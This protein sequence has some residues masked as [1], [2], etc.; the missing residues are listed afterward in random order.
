[1]SLSMSHKRPGDGEIDFSDTDAVYDHILALLDNLLDSKH[2]LSRDSHA[3]MAL[4]DARFNLQFWC[5]GI[6]I[7]TNALIEFSGHCPKQHA[8]LFSSFRRL[9]QCLS[10]LDQGVK[11][12]GTVNGIMLAELPGRVESVLNWGKTLSKYWKEQCAAA[13]THTHASRVRENEDK[14]EEYDGQRRRSKAG[15]SQQ[16]RPQKAVRAVL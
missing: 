10:T 4:L 3:S 6:F 5:S 9:L 15:G 13:G 7:E 14:G 16:R 8:A 12:Y 1:M 2:P 11:L